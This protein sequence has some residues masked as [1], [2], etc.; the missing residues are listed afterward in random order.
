MFGFTGLII[1]FLIFSFLFSLLPIFEVVFSLQYFSLLFPA[2]KLSYIPSRMFFNFMA[3]FFISCY[4]THIYVDIYI[5]ILDTAYLVH[6]TLLVCL[7]S[8]LMIWHQTTDWFALP[9]G[10]PHLP[11]PALLSFLQCVCVELRCPIDFFPIEFGM[12]LGVL[13]VQLMF[14]QLCQ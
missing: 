1:L 6:I 9:W 4:C 12:F 10:E 11:L 3:S 7:F 2:S 5:Y 8:G 14:G 13:L